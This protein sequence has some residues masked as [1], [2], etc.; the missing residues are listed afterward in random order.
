MTSDFIWH[1]MFSILSSVL[2]YWLNFAGSGSTQ[3][4][5]PTLVFPNEMDGVPKIS[6]PTFAMASYKLKGSVWMQN[7]LGE[8]QL[9]N[10]L[11]QAAGNW[12]RLLQ[13]NHPDYQFF[14]SHGTYHRWFMRWLVDPSFWLKLLA[15]NFYV[16]SWCNVVKSPFIYRRINVGLR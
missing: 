9:A 15:M 6:L 12:L 1:G 3:A 11:S 10:S 16:N 8:N 14:L 4:Q 2:N 5:A 7:G 13:V